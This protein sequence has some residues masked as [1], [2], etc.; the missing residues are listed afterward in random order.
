MVLFVGHSLRTMTQGAVRSVPAR[1]AGPGAVVP[2]GHADRARDGAGSGRRRARSRS[3]PRRSRDRPP[4]ARPGRSAP[5]PA[6]SSPC[7]RAIRARST[8][9]GSCAARCARARWC[10]T[11]SWRRRCRHSP[12]TRSRCARGRVPRRSRCASS[13]IALVSG[14]DVLFQPLNPLARPGARAAAVERGDPAAGDL[15]PADRAEAAGRPALDAGRGR[16][17]RSSGRR[18]SGRCT[19]RSTRPRWAAARAMR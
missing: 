11:S 4:R 1:L 3:R 16:G 7:R 8:R 10:S 9:S 18:C 19:R 5:A 14:T 12:A 2:R 13:G 6:R 15:R 17:A